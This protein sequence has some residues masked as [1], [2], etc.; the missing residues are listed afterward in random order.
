MNKLN[1]SIIGLSVVLLTGLASNAHKK[2]GDCHKGHKGEKHGKHLIEMADTNED[3]KLSLEEMKI[4]AE[5]RF[6]AG[7]VNKDGF[8][9]Q[10]EIKEQFKNRKKKKDTL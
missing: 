10:A 7:D 9:E 5:S 4:N 1:L 6:L 8:L 2:E 3:G